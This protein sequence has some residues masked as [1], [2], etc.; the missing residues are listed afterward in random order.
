MF[1]SPSVTDI[2]SFKDFFTAK[3]EFDLEGCSHKSRV[4]YDHGLDPLVRKNRIGSG[5]LSQQSNAIW[6]NAQLDLRDEYMAGIFALAKAGKL[7]WSSGTAPHLVE[8]K[9]IDTYEGTVHEVLKWPLGLD[10]SVTPR[11]ADPRNIVEVKSLLPDNGIT[12]PTLFQLLGNVE[13]KAQIDAIRDAAGAAKRAFSIPNMTKNGSLLTPNFGHKH[14]SSGPFSANSTPDLDYFQAQTDPILPQKDQV[15]TQ[16]E[17]KIA[18]KGAFSAQVDALDGIFDQNMPQNWPTTDPPPARGLAPEK[19]EKSA[20]LPPGRKFFQ[21]NL[22]FEKTSLGIS[23]E[24]TSNSMRG[25]YTGE[26]AGYK[27]S[28][29]RNAPDDTFGG[30][31][32]PD[33]SRGNTLGGYDSTLYSQDSTLGGLNTPHHSRGNTLHTSEDSIGRGETKRDA[34]PRILNQIGELENN[35]NYYVKCDITQLERGRNRWEATPSSQ[36][37]NPSQRPMPQGPYP[38]QSGREKPLDAPEDSS[39]PHFTFPRWIHEIQATKSARLKEYREGYDRS[40]AP[41]LNPY[42]HADRLP[43]GW[44]N[45]YMQYAE[46][47]VPAWWA[48]SGYRFGRPWKDFAC[49]LRRQI[50][51]ERAIYWKHQSGRDPDSIDNMRA[52]EIAYATSYRKSHTTAAREIWR[53]YN[54]HP[55]PR[56]PISVLDAPG[57][58]TVRNP[59][60]QGDTLPNDWRIAAQLNV[61]PNLEDLGT[62]LGIRDKMKVQT[63]VEEMYTAQRGDRKRFQAAITRSEAEGEEGLSDKATWPKPILLAQGGARQEEIPSSRTSASGGGRN[64]YDER[65]IVPRGFSETIYG[66]GSVTVADFIYRTRGTADPS[67]VSDTDIKEI[68]HSLFDMFLRAR[69]AIQKKNRS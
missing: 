5:R 41:G 24:I 57:A 11:P 48:E 40:D 2:S 58:G 52:A 54:A 69:A 60:Y 15:L 28:H 23:R 39:V 6:I 36:Q 62:L 56:W 66:G 17:P 27:K 38:S 55:Q 29:L 44:W 59:Y 19:F 50:L 9:S 67:E 68:R 32:S 42:C 10:A 33:S 1:G 22:K 21:S 47:S 20:Q 30:F 45:L 34:M 46:P 13:I 12:T 31:N 16:N 49:E 35:Y 26:Y 63:I 8:R 14:A 4:Y 37:R 53:P 3:T 7:S 18:P 25:G 51:Q 61:T 64:P 43:D 65:D